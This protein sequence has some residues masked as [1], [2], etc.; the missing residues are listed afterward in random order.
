M[1]LPPPTAERDF[2]ARF[3]KLVAAARYSKKDSKEAEA[4]MLA[5]ESLHKQVGVAACRV[6]VEYVGLLW[7]V[8]AETGCWWGSAAAQIVCAQCACRCDGGWLTDF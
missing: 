8:V 3:G 1:C 7:L 5:L 6:C 4:G 2:Q